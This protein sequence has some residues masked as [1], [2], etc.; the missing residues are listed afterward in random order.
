LNLG[1]AV[2]AAV[3]I[4]FHGIAFA[5]VL[6]LISVGLSV[7]MGMMGFVNLAHGVFAMLGGYVLTSL[8]S[9]AG[10]PFAPALA[11][12]AVATAL[13]S[14]IVEQLLYRRLYGGDELDQVLLT[15]G[16]IFMSFAA[17]TYLW[18]PNPQP[19]H[20]PRWLAGEVDLGFRS[21]PAFRSFLIL[22]GAA[23]VT[24]LWLGLER[25]RFGVQIRA[26]V[27]NLRMAQSVGI[28][29][30][31]LFTLTFALGSGL[32]GLGG[33][34]GADLLSIDPSYALDNLV[35][36][37]IV[38]AVGG[39]GSIRGPFV[40][41]LLIGIAD[42]GFKYLLPELGA[43]FIYAL[44]AAILLWRPRGLFGRA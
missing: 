10:V 2:S 4:A 44:T 14:V 15:M 17:V 8:M 5:M 43:F 3:S 40:A 41:A 24:L 27:D 21:F 11:A 1:D 18:G 29:T 19:M 6:Y 30:S 12:A 13:G 9:R 42:T 38:V 23:L 25:T 20:P 26:A 34:L 33:G 7:T 39:L 31:R 22:C 37:L 16:L 36:F 32:A 35:Y 28:N